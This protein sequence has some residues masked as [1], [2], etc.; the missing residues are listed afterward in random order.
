MRKIIAPF[1]TASRR[2][3]L[4]HLGFRSFLP[5]PHLR[6]WIQCY[7][8]V[9][10]PRFPIQGFSEKLYPDGGT[11]INFRFIS[12]QIPLVTFNAVQTLKAAWNRIAV[13]FH[14]LPVT[15]ICNS[16]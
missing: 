1:N 3:I 16:H 9:Q 14:F 8:A 4:A 12:G 5:H 2:S 6:S 13:G 7:W 10:Q 11:N 15:K